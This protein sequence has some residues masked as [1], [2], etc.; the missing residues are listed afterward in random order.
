MMKL[1]VR[2]CP[3]CKSTSGE[4]L[5]TMVFGKLKGMPI[6]NQYDL[7]ACSECGFTFSDT[8]STQEAYDNYYAYM[9]KYQDTQA[10]GSGTNVYDLKRLEESAETIAHYVTNKEANILDMGCANGGL[11]V[12]LKEQGYTNLNGMDPA[13]RC[14]ENVLRKGIHAQQGSVF[15]WPKD[16]EKKYDCIILTHVLEHIRDLQRGLKLLQDRL[17]EDGILYIEVPNAGMYS[18]AYVVPFY[19]FDLEHINHFDKMSIQNALMAMQCIEV[20]EVFQNVNQQTM[21]PVLKSVFSNK[22]SQVKQ[23]IKSTIGKESIKIYIEKSLKEYSSQEIKHLVVT[24]EPVFVWGAGQYTLRLLGATLFDKCNILGFIDNDTHK[25][26]NKIKGIEIYDKSKLEDFKGTIVIVSAL[27]SGQ[28]KEEI[29]KMGMT[30][31]LI[32]L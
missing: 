28:I 21:Y 8:Y 27:G 24:Q 9:S 25:Q 2:Q 18:S 6:A 32:I 13:R 3:I 26:G 11:L 31:K 17:N 29:E 5:H 15:N 12:Q 4:V 22:G 10:T 23:S 14:M 1:L 30:N 19:Y 16:D 20:E 7:V